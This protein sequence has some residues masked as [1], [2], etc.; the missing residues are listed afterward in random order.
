MSEDE[1]LE[2]FLKKISF[3]NIEFKFYD[4]ADLSEEISEKLKKLKI[5]DFDKISPEFIDTLL[6][7]FVKQHYVRIE[8]TVKPDMAREIISFTEKLIAE[9]VAREK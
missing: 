3:I 8:F 9:Q 4:K 7:K 6:D 1:K 5:M 2:D